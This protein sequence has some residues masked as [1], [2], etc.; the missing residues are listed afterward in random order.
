MALPQNFP[1]PNRIIS[2]MSTSVLVVEG[3]QHSR[4]AITA[5]LARDQGRQVFAVPGN[6]TSKLSGALTC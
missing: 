1:I 6:T 2:G 5:K 4:S 3:A